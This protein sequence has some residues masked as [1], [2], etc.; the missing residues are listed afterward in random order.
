M[1]VYI[2]EIYEDNLVHKDG[3]GY[4]IDFGLSGFMKDLEFLTE[5]RFEYMPGMYILDELEEYDKTASRDEV[6][7]KMEEYE[8]R[9]LFNML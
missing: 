6:I 5:E 7:R 9:W 1:Q 3:T 4:F 2:T 8:I